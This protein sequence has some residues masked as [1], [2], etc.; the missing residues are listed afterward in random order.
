MANGSMQMMRLERLADEK[1]RVEEKLQDL[2][3]LAEEESRDFNEFENEQQAKYRTRIGKL[4]EEILVLASDV[5][6]HNTAVDVSSVLRE[7]EADKGNGASENGAVVYRHF[8]EY[9]RDQLIVHEKWGNK[10]VPLIGGDPTAVREAAQER[11]ERTLQNTTSTTVA[12]LIIPTH[13]TEIMDIISR[14]RPVV[15]S[16][17]QVPLDKGSM[18]YPKIDT[19][20]TVV[21]Q[22]SEKTE[23]GTVAPAVS[24]ATLQ[25]KTYLG[26]TN[27]SWQ[28]ANWSSPDVLQL[29][30]ELAAEAY[31]RQTEGQA[32]EVMETSNIGTVGTASGR[33]GTAGTE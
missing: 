3:A 7:K 1:T 18:T 19:R 14:D 23:G 13:L 31:A 27:V 30:F 22:T 12:G 2:I 10:I 26:A 24:S 20:P 9:A 32:C 21:E 4:D 11:L 6:R 25:A 28:A 8:S 5:E 29:Y 16:G 15:A 33:L 17:R